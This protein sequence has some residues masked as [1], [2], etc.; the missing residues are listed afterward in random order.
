MEPNFDAY[1]TRDDRQ[2]KDLPH[3]EDRPCRKCNKE[4]EEEEIKAGNID[5]EWEQD[6]DD[7]GQCVSWKFFHVECPVLADVKAVAA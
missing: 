6:W 4:F 1:I 3:P 7:E 2:Y 5:A